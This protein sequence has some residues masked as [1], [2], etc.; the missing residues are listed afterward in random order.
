MM[1]ELGM[2][3]RSRKAALLHC[4]LDFENCEQRIGGSKVQ[5]A[6]L[7]NGWVPGASLQVSNGFE[8]TFAQNTIEYYDA[9]KTHC[10]LLLWQDLS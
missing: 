9:N 4:V 2:E 1:L 6:W 8:D 7:C 3:G 5:F 10:R